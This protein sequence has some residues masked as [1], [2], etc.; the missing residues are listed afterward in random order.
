MF[1]RPSKV[2]KPD[3]RIDP[4]KWETVVYALSVFTL[5]VRPTG[6]R[7]MASAYAA[8]DYFKKAKEPVHKSDPSLPLTPKFSHIQVGVS[9]SI[10]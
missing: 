4:I 3:A 8:L 2:I 10:V 9:N 5:M 1:K 6:G 7:E